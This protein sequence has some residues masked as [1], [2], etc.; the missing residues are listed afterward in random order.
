MKIGFIGNMNNYPFTLALALREQGADVRFLVDSTYPLCRPEG[1]IAGTE[2]YGDWIFDLAPMRTWDVVL[3]TPKRRRALALLADRDAIVA[4]NWGIALSALAGKPSFVISTG[5]DLDTL[6]NAHYLDRI[7]EE[8][9]PGWPSRLRNASKYWLYRRLIPL[10][11]EGFRRALGVEYAWPGVLP[12]GDRL[13]AEIGV[14]GER[15]HSFMLTD[16]DQLKRTPPPDNPVPRVLVVARVNW[17]EPLPPGFSVLDNK[18]T[19][20]FLEGAARYVRSGQALQIRL[21]RKGL[22]LRETEALIARLGL[23][24]HVVWL[25]EMP[26][27]AFVRQ[28]VEADIVADH[29]G[30][31]TI[32]IGAR[33]AFAIGRPVIAGGDPDQFRSHAGE[34]LPIVNARDP[35]EVEAALHRLRDPR[36]RAAAA[37]R[38]RGFAERHFSTANAA[39]AMLDVFARS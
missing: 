6:A 34:S 20:I 15:R 31:G 18:R 38:S 32:G 21:F 27:T 37:D 29:F 26:Q 22:H 16:L 30:E 24:D 10:Q 5:S 9:G 36:Q 17:K 25:D 28:I 1:R 35:A 12:H 11:R 8:G 19:D 23:D 3:P 2:G 7:G 33:D 4:N 13:L 14:A 39:R